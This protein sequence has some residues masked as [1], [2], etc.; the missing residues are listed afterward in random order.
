MKRRICLVTGSRAE[1]GLLSGLAREIAGDPGLELQLIATGSHLDPRFGKTAEE[2]RAQGFTIDAEVPLDLKDD[3]KTA[4]AQA[5]GA[6]LGGLAQ[7]YARLAPD[8]VALLGD[9]YEIFA[10]AS[11]ALLLGI[12]VAHI[13]GGESTEGAVDD[14]L[15]HAITK[16]SHLHFAAAAPYAQRIV[17][18]GEEPWRVHVVGAPGVDA[19]LSPAL[20]DAVT[21]ERD[22]GQPM[23]HPLL[24]VTYHPV[25]LRQ[26]GEGQAVDA[27]LAA[28]DEFPQA[29]IVITGANADPGRE[30]IALRLEA[31]AKA[32]APRVSL[33]ASLGQARYLGVMKL[34]DAV[35]GNSSSGIIEAPALGVPTVDIGSRQGGRLKAS[36]VISCGEGKDEIARAIS[37]ALDP[38]FRASIAHQNPPYGGG[39]A[40]GRMKDILAS[41]DLKLGT[42][43]RFHDLAARP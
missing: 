12:P 18:M 19:A 4:I 17:Q 40:A 3:S 6:A 11:A 25:T 15:R 42:S 1:W 16:M 20:P 30:E 13:H 5:M 27:L 29:R 8:I 33:H 43:K 38:A 22:L 32:R 23:T 35:I 24:L 21:L 26:G 7:A 10:A 36:S 39:G 31:F 14:Q 37:Q 28:L 34:A 9:R 2:I 41:P